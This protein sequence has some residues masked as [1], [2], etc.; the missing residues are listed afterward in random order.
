MKNRFRILAI[1]MCTAACLAA[2]PMFLTA[3]PADDK[4]P[5][6]SAAAAASAQAGS[7]VDL[8]NA[9]EKEL[10]TL[11][12][13]GPA[14]AKKIISGRPYSS[15]A[16]LSRAGVNSATI[17]KITPLV[18]VGAA[19]AKAAAAPP[20][21]APAP[22]ASNPPPVTSQTPA[23]ARVRPPSTASSVAPPADSTG[24]VWVNKD[25]KIYHKPGDRYY[26]NTK[27]GEYMR[28]SDAIAQGYRA[29]KQK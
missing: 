1:V 22:K 16:D 6:K 2:A 9:T 26:G 11:P 12:G 28:E 10:D 21:P 18:T 23:D 4:K 20:A 3:A 8:N 29:S 14:T 15:V 5:S 13:V 24:M 27:N 25:S 7:L 17:S 19:P